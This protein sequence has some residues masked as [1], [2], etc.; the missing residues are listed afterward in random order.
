MKERDRDR[1][2]DRD[3]NREELTNGHSSSRDPVDK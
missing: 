1:D 2:R 3:R